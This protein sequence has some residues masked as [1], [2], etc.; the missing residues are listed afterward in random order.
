MATRGYNYLV[1]VQSDGTTWQPLRIRGGNFPEVNQVHGSVDITAHGDSGLPWRA[2][3][4]TLYEAQSVTV[5]VL[6]GGSAENISALAF[7]QGLIGS[8]TGIDLRLRDHTGTAGDH[9]TLWEG[10]YLVTGF[11]LQAPL[12]D[13][14][15]YNVDLLLQGEPTTHF[16]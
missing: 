15:S 3:L 6:S 10:T 16:G 12:E 9:T 11:T 2:H 13:A 4:L 14:V 7:V 8:E 5:N 1:Q